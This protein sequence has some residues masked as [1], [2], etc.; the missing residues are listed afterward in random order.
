M[1]PPTAK[2]WEY[3]I[4]FLIYGLVT[5]AVF[6]FRI[7]NFLTH[8]GMPDVD[9]DGT[10][11]YFWARVFTDS[12][13]IFFDSSA[14]LF[15]FPFGYDFSYIPFF[16]LIYEA[17]IY[18]IKLFGGSWQAI[19]G[20]TNFSM[21]ISYPLTA[22]SA[23]ELSYYVTRNKYASFV[24]GLIFSFSSYHILMGRGSLTNNH[25]EFIPLYFLSLM[26][27][28]DRKSMWAII[29]SALAFTLAFMTNAYWAFFCGLFSPLFVLFYNS[30]SVKNTLILG[31]KYYA[32]L[33][34]VLVLT[35]INYL[36]S[37][38]YLF[39]KS[40][41]ASIAGKLFVPESQVIQVSGFFTPSV[42]SWLYPTSANGETFL[43]FAAIALG[44]VGVFMLR[45]NRKFVLF[46]GCFLLS[47]LL[48]SNIPG[49]FFINKIYFSLFG[50]FRAV[51]R[52]NIFSTLF[53]S[54]MAALTLSYLIPKIRGYEKKAVMLV[55]IGA[56]SI[57]VVSD[58][59]TKDR[60]FW[61]VTDFSKSAE[62]YEPIRDN[63]EIKVIAAYPMI[64]SNG[65]NGF[66]MGYQLFGQMIYQ[67]PMV[68]GV[69]PHIPKALEFYGKVRNINS[70]STIDELGDKGVD[71][72][73][74]YRNLMSNSTTTINKLKKDK[75]LAYVG[76]FTTAI[77]VASYVSSN[78]L[79]RDI[80]VFQIKKVVEE[81][82]ELTPI[83]I[84]DGDINIYKVSDHQIQIDL[85]GVPPGSTLYFNHPFSSGWKLYEP[86][87]NLGASDWSFVRKSP[88]FEDS[89]TETDTY[90]N[91]WT[92]SGEEIQNKMF[93]R[94]F[95]VNEDGTT[96]MRLTLYYKPRLYTNIGTLVAILTVAICLGYVAYARR[97]EK[98]E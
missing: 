74:I 94:W 39:V 44:V 62:L 68:N 78:D 32:V 58:S 45:K 83:S 28:L 4:V 57:W 25:F 71:T 35:N 87:A 76:N 54:V 3:L 67:K 59:L 23:F 33:F 69:S 7:P 18:L 60:T 95:K 29:L 53:I 15:G 84:S 31:I 88:I 9:T 47:V 26:Y 85:T 2:K 34:G 91:M 92:I 61:K 48:A 14:S 13:L 96:D 81:R 98:L 64:L 66:P 93:K 52:I 22:L 10:M 40:N 89:H 75:R 72:I 20:V 46:F 65:T 80:T 77:D 63:P 79:A 6:W 55:I 27:A 16:S 70:T 21:L 1:N 43:G 17:T 90:G 36:T 73:M 12:H 37:Q 82:R 49:L 97:K 30:S 8:Y 86:G 42:N 56:I 51:S 38:S 24:A 50:M 19:V 5:L 11:W 41:I